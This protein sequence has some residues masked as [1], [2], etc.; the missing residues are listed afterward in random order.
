MLET[1]NMSE[2]LDQSADLHVQFVEHNYSSEC[3]TF[4]LPFIVPSILLTHRH[5]I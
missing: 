5:L 1:V 3:F 2:A 4:H